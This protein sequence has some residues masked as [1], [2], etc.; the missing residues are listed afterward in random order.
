MQREAEAFVA[1]VMWKS[2]ADVRELFAADWT[3]A[4]DALARMYL[5]ESDGQPPARSAGRVSLGGVRRRGILNQAAFLSVYAHATETAP[6][7]RGVAVL[8]RVVCVDIP[9]PTS[10]N[11]NVV[12]PIPDPSKTT[13]ERF[14]IHSQDA[15]CAGCHKSIDPLGF[16]FEALD[17]MGR[18]RQMENGRP[19]DSRTT[20]AA[21]Y[22]FDGSYA[23]SAELALRLA[24]S[25]E[26]VSCFARQ[27]YRYAAARSDMTAQASESA[28]MSEVATLP[29]DSRAKFA[30]LLV[31]L[32][33]SEGFVHRGA[34]L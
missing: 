27:L 3:L 8:R 18:A 33:A 4:D 20:L 15:A 7:L 14:S 17:G 2:S 11:L 22:S 34:S 12:P 26:L 1:E 24:D 19:V 9:S 25:A 29:Q 13:R 10:L 30:E 5:G 23:D 16:S 21:G 32:V 31:A 6:V 28:F